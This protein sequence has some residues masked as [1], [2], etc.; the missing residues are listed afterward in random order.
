METNLKYI[1]L[2]CTD[3]GGVGGHNLNIDGEN[4]ICTLLGGTGGHSLEINALNE[5]CTIQGVTAG[6]S[7][8]LAA[9]SAI[10]ATAYKTNLEAWKNIQ[11][12]T[13]LNYT[14]E[15][16][17]VL[18]AM[19]T[20][21]N[22][23]VKAAQNKF[24]KTL[25]DAGVFAK[26]DQAYLL[27]GHTNDNSESLLNI[28]NP[29]A[30]NALL[31]FGSGGSVPVFT[32]LRGFKGSQ[33]NKSYIN[34]TVNEV[35]HG[36]KYK[37]N[38]ASYL[39]YVRQMPQCYTNSLMGSGGG[40]ANLSPF[41]DKPTLSLFGTFYGGLNNTGLG[42]TANALRPH[43]GLYAVTR[44][45]A[46][47]VKKYSKPHDTVEVKAA[48]STNLITSLVTL[49]T[50]G[51]NYDESQISFAA[52]GGALT[53]SD[54]D[55]VEAAIETYRKD[56]GDHTISIIGDSIMAEK[57]IAASAIS[58]LMDND[59]YTI[60][61]QSVSSDKIEDQKLDWAELSAKA[62]RYID[63]VFVNVGINN[64]IP[65]TLAQMLVKYQDLIDTI[66]ADTSPACKIVGVTMIP[67]AYGAYPEWIGLNA[68]I[69]DGTITGL[70]ATIN[71]AATA[72][73]SG[74][75]T[76]AAAYDSGD[77]VHPNQAGRIILAGL[78]DAKL[79]ELGL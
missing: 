35:A 55:V 51:A 42:G 17:A 58:E 33:A 13:L 19:T 38:D 54:I 10:G 70:D 21:P 57:T 9:L 5:I 73:N 46:T 71:T 8:N 43:P 34:T 68:A 31:A 64:I 63:C 11:E 27:Q 24:I 62:K 77:T 76:L 47:E 75:N 59:N 14:D 56:I 12:G 79:T 74:T 72:L 22:A 37:L 52:I 39:I 15:Y 44:E 28:I 60:I 66:R 65:D 30:N 67:M 26:W 40:Q 3:L 50:I 45:V 69:L 7:L 18:A 48:N 49:L 6:H 36:V 23:M 1:N 20:Q 25:I 2:I 78:Y 53:A 29:A 32:A 4:E 16:K 41:F 61:D